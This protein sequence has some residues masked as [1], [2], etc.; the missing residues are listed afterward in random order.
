MQS[1]A[2][3]LRSWRRSAARSQAAASPDTN[4]TSVFAHR[5]LVD[6]FA[7]LL[8]SYR[9]MKVIGAK[10]AG[11]WPRD[12]QLHDAPSLSRSRYVAGGMALMAVGLFAL[13]LI[14][15]T[16]SLFLIEAALLI[17]G[18]GLG[19]NTGP[20]NAVAVANA[21][22]ARSG[23]ASGLVNTARMLGATLGVAVV[24]ALFAVFGRGNAAAGLAPAYVGG[25]VAASGLNRGLR[26]RKA[27]ITTTSDAPESDIAGTVPLRR[28]RRLRPLP[29]R[30][31]PRHPRPHRA[32]AAWAGH[33]A[34]RQTG[35]SHWNGLPLLG[36]RRSTP[37]PQRRKFLRQPSHG[38]P[39]FTAL[40]E[41]RIS[42]A[43]REDFR[44]SAERQIR[45]Q[46]RI[47]PRL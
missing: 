3:S 22:A 42:F 17:N 10:Y 26:P 43:S 24:G 36:L 7:A 30:G 11:L 6:E 27:S 29:R 45:G 23:T 12:R 16:E 28:T 33:Q 40:A 35:H 13:A 39:N 46:P 8:K 2:T 4:P 32:P 9:V 47:C 38:L 19:L 44:C 37:Q 5:K 25:G 21:P 41:N 15:L 34:A 18:C 1:C 20:V 14:P 31:L